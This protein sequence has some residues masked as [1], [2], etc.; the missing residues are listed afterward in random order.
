[1]QTHDYMSCNI[2]TQIPDYRKLHHIHADTCMTTCPAAFPHRYMTTGNY[3]TFIK[4]LDYMFCSIFTQ[5][6][7]YIKVQYIHVDT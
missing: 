6:P 7:D 3:S 5:I 2:S 1:M 4:T